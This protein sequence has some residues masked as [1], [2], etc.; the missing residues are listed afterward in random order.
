[1][2]EYDAFED[3]QELEG[4]NAAQLE[5]VTST[6]G[7]IRV[8][9]LNDMDEIQLF[10]VAGNL[11]ESVKPP[12]I[13]NCYEYEVLGCID[14]IAKGLAVDTL[15]A[16]RYARKGLMEK[17]L[18]GQQRGPV[19]QELSCPGQLGYRRDAGDHL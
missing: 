2:Y 8:Q 18:G 4:L 1:M 10:D 9:N 7:F 3:I 11:V 14:A 16:Y 17:T 19:S 13:E 5:A 6:E 12:R 15:R